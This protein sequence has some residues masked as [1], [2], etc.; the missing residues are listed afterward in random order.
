MDLLRKLLNVLFVC[1]VLSFMILGTIIVAIQFYSIIVANGVLAVG[2]AKT[3]GK[4]AF[5]IATITGLIGFIQ[6]YVNGWEMGD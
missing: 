2:I 3:L 6:G 5:A 1:G 4:P